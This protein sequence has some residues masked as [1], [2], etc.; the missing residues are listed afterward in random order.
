MPCPAILHYTKVKYHVSE[1]YYAV[2]DFS[3]ISCSLIII[4]IASILHCFEI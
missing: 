3:L 1:L 2:L 4:S